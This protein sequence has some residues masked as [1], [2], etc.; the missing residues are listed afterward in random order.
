MKI[1]C[2]YDELVDIN[3]VKPNPENRNDHPIAQIQR[4]AK[5]LEYQGIR[6][7]LIVSKK[8]KL[9]V[10]GHGRLEAMKQLK[11]D[12]VPVVYQTFK[13]KEQEYAFAVSDNAIASWADLELAKINEHLKELD[14][15]NF[16][17]DLLG[18]KDFEIEV[19]DKDD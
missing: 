17:I 3:K 5:I 4:L 19:A 2:K 10:V 9:L 18:I 7:P 11:M 14:G 12:K 16:D 15:I 8:S 6:H 1:V 13:D